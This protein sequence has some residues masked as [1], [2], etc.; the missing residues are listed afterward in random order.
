MLLLEYLC[1]LT[2]V[3]V[4]TVAAQESISSYAPT[5]VPCPDDLRIRPAR[6]GLNQQEQEWRVLRLA[7]VANSLASYLKD[8]NIPHF[9][10]GAYLDQMN[11][12]TAPIAGLAIS[13]GGSTSGLG[14]LGLWQAF[15]NRYPPSVEA[16]KWNFEAVQGYQ[17]QNPGFPLLFRG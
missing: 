7:V 16:G 8:A 14:G 15:D 5:I 12:S 13:G 4:T 10:A 9:H 17:T 1:V 3:A 6:N 11:F 2:A